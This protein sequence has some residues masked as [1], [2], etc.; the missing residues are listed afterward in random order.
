[1]KQHHNDTV[2]TIPRYASYPGSSKSD[3]NKIPLGL[4][5][6]G[7]I[8]WDVSKEPM[9]LL[10]GAT[11]GGK[12]V[13]QRNII[14]HCIQH[15]DRWRFIGIDIK[16]VELSPYKKYDDIVMGIATNVADGVE[17]LRYASE[18]MANRYAEM[19][20]LGVNHFESLPNVPYTLMVMI[21]EAYLFL[22]KSQNNNLEEVTEENEL[23]SEASRIIGDIARLGRAAGVHLVLA[24]QRP[25]ATIVYG[26]LKYN[27]SCRIV[28]G[29]VDATTSQMVLNND[30]AALIPQD[31][32]GRG[33]IQ[34]FGKG[35][36]FQSYYAEQN[37]IDRFLA[38]EAPDAGDLTE[39]EKPVRRSF[40]GS[41]LRRR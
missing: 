34:V 10:T 39:S 11:G 5:T 36:Q 40:L 21:D 7:E 1:M 2:T 8:F 24:T 31:I 32:K 29:K 16:Q 26:E 30:N 38:G 4:G 6:E 20:T 3:W 19:E 18:E 17:A 27:L 13:I 28:A 9:L 15:S 25:D 12:S 33:Y 14:F 37:W 41:R 35:E 22:V 23:K